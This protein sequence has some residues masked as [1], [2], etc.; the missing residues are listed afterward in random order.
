M[1]GP[2]VRRGLRLSAGAGVA[3]TRSCG[4]HGANANDDQRP[5]TCLAALRVVVSRNGRVSESG[6]I[7]EAGV[8]SALS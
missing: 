2:D 7:E 6:G 5:P 8:A 3:P 4:M 1:A